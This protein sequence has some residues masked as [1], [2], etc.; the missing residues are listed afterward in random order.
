MHQPRPL[1]WP[2]QR[3]R[4]CARAADTGP[5]AWPSG[6]SI[7]T[8]RPRSSSCSCEMALEACQRAGPLEC[9]PDHNSHMNGKLARKV[10]AERWRPPGGRV[11]EIRHLARGTPIEVLRQRSEDS[12]VEIKLSNDPGAPI[13]LVPADAIDSGTAKAM[14]IH[15]PPRHRRSSGG[16]RV[17]V[18]WKPD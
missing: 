8:G 4:A 16:S 14:S 12:R 7:A 17:P 13:F 3:E 18:D 11:Q 1:P 5:Q 2:A 15:R 9:S 6:R 10:I